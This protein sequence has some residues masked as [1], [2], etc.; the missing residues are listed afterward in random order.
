MTWLDTDA[1]PMPD[2]AEL[3]HQ[4]VHGRLL[5]RALYDPDP[6]E[7]EGAS[8]IIERLARCAAADR[9]GRYDD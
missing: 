8:R 4:R 5:L 1:P 9:A 6:V 2:E 3:D 7:R